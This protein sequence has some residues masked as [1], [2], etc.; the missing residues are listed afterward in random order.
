MQEEVVTKYA[1]AWAPSAPAADTA[2]RPRCVTLTPHEQ[3][4]PPG[5]PHLPVNLDSRE[6]VRAVVAR[7]DP[8]EQGS[9]RLLP[10]LALSEAELGAD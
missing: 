5:L 6:P 3:V 9:M 4:G 10:H 2:T 8:N 1:A 7:T